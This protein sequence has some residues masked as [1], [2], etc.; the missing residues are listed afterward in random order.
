MFI[1]LG[2]ASRCGWLLRISI[3]KQ[4]DNALPQSRLEAPASIL[5]LVL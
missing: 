1:V 2:S 3:L 5:L 4:I